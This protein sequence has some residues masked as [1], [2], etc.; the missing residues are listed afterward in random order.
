MTSRTVRADMSEIQAVGIIGAKPRADST[1]AH[2][3][4]QF[5]DKKWR[6]SVP[7]VP[8]ASAC[9]TCVPGLLPHLQ[10]GD[11]VPLRGRFT[12]WGR[13]WRHRTPRRLG[14]AATPNVTL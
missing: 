4:P 3:V 11:G 5:D 7:L 9:Y 12:I 10:F 14:I 6:N 1:Q 13:R 2:I 8:I